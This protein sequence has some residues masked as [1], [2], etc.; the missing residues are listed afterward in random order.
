MSFTNVYEDDR[1][2]AAYDKLEFPGTYFLAFRDLP[3]LF[4]QHIRGTQALDFGCGAGRSTRF[5]KRLGF[6]ALG[7]DISEDMLSRARLRDADGRYLCVDEEGLGKLPESGF[8]LIFSAFTFDNIPTGEKK[9]FYFRELANRLAPD[10]KFVNL[11]SAPEIYT[12]EWA[13]FTTKAFPENQL[14]KSGEQVRIVMTDVEDDRPVIDVLWSEESYRQ[15]CQQA[16]LKIINMIKPLGTPEEP[17][18]WVNETAVAPW[19]IYVLGR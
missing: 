19:T 3:A 16:G 1:R 5:L 8:H 17:F 7:V 9:L 18:D 14:A 15:L 2:A 11:V 6:E 12:H 4:I 13:S 10:G